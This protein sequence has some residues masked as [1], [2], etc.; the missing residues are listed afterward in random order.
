[1]EKEK[2]LE[3]NEN[4]FLV[5]YILNNIYDNYHYGLPKKINYSFS[6]LVPYKRLLGKR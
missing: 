4:L 1:M 2:I 6:N 5:Y 3:F